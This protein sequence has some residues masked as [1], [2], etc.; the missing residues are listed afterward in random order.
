MTTLE[1]VTPVCFVGVET[2]QKMSARKSECDG[3]DCPLCNL[4][5]GDHSSLQVAQGLSLFGQ[6]N[7][8]KR[9]LGDLEN[10]LGDVREASKSAFGGGFGRGYPSRSIL[11][12]FWTPF[13]EGFWALNRAQ[14][15]PEVKFKEAYASKIDSEPIWNRFDID[16]ETILER[17]RALS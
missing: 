8:K 9:L 3:S 7:T 17:L 12:Q 4:H 13:W 5:D 6:K 16:L 1:F 2:S 15:G 11:D 14:M 10:A